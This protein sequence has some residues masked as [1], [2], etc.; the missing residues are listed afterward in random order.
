MSSV[1]FCKNVGGFYTLNTSA[2][3][4]WY[5]DWYH[6][7]ICSLRC[8]LHNYGISIHLIQAQGEE[9]TGFPPAEREIHTRDDHLSF[10]VWKFTHSVMQQGFSPIHT[11]QNVYPI[12]VLMHNT[13][14]ALRECECWEQIAFPIHLR[15]VRSKFPMTCS[16]WF[17]CHC[18]SD[19]RL[20]AV[21]AKNGVSL[22]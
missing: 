4:G 17:F 22:V 16:F 7:L 15:W 12:Y 14:F 3:V 6:E 19:P 9:L 21:T 2:V 8:R 13:V 5:Q 18:C 1:C 20:Y 11:I 10:Q